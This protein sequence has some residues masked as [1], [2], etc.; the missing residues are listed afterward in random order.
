MSSALTRI[1][2]ACQRHCAHTWQLQ[3]GWLPDRR[4]SFCGLV[5]VRLVE[6]GLIP[7]GGHTN[8]WAGACIGQSSQQWGSSCL[9]GVQKCLRP[10][11]ITR[12][13]RRRCVPS[14]PRHATS[15]A[16]STTY[17]APAYPTKRTAR[18]TRRRSPCICPPA[19][20]SQT[21]RALPVSA[22]RGSALRPSRTGKPPESARLAVCRRPVGLPV[23]FPRAVASPYPVPESHPSGDSCVDS[24]S[25][26]GSARRGCRLVPATGLCQR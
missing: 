18:P 25:V 6:V 15:T 8:S 22:T 23:P 1:H 10:P 11:Q 14:G 17:A 19:G 12:C 2:D 13:A 3:F 7:S 4:C 26:R 20:C 16:R 5:S 9:A 21:A 24:S